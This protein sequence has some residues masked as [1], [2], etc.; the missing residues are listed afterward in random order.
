AAGAASATKRR[1]IRRLEI[2]DR[3]ASLRWALSRQIGLG[4]FR[5][6]IRLGAAVIREQKQWSSS[7]PL[8]ASLTMPA[9][10]WG[11]WGRLSD[12]GPGQD[13]PDPS[14]DPWGGGLPHLHGGA[15][16]RSLTPPRHTPTLRIGAVQRVILAPRCRP[17]KGGLLQWRPASGGGTMLWS[18]PVGRFGGTEVKIHITFLLLLAWIAFSAR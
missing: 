1:P 9:R 6:R 2:P 12:D 18:I 3:S 8:Y 10:E 15:L 11:G 14:E 17:Q 5:R 7:L 13:N 4:G 16:T